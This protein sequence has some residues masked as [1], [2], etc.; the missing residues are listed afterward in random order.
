MEPPIN[1]SKEVSYEQ[2][3]FSLVDAAKEQ[4]NQIGLSDA[5]IQ[6]YQQRSFNRII[7]RYQKEDEYQYRQE[8][9][10]ELLVNFEQQFSDGVISR[11]SGNWRR[12]GIK[13]LQKIYQNGRFQWRVYQKYSSNELPEAFENYF[14][15][16]G[17]IVSE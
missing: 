15:F 10:N 12:R 4:M 5:T 1:F 7:Q 11:K 8:I 16:Y 13:I 17:R 6:T 9:M 14:Q 3:H 2:R